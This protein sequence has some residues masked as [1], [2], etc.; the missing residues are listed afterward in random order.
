MYG[1]YGMAPALHGVFSPL[2][3]NGVVRSR[4]VVL[5]TLE[6]V[7]DEAGGSKARNGRARDEFVAE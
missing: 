3:F 4:T 6:V 5:V 1:L 7:G 2:G